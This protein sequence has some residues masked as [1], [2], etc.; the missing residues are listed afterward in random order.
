M[1]GKNEMK[2]SACVIVKNEEKNLPKWLDCMKKIA[3]ELIVVDTG[4]TDCT[5]KLAKESGAV[6][7][8]YDWVNDFASAKNFAITK[9]TGDW[10]LFLDADE[11]FSDE[12]IKKIPLYL[13]RLKKQNWIDAVTCR[14]INIDTDVKGRVINSFSNIRIFR[15][16]PYLRYTNNVHENLVNQIKEL[17]I[18]SLDKVIDVYHTGYSG[19]VIKEKLTRNLHLLKQDI[20]QNG[21]QPKHYR[22][23]CDCYHGLADFENT[24]KYARKH[25]A[26]GYLT[27]GGDHEIYKRLIDAMIFSQK[28]SA[29][30]LCTIEEAIAAYP[31]E[32]TFL[33]VEG[34]FL[35]KNEKYEQAEICLKAALLLDKNKVV[36]EY[37]TDL[38]ILYRAETYYD[39][40]KIMKIKYKNDAALQYMIQ[41]LKKNPYHVKL[42]CF[43]MDFL[44]LNE[45]VKVIQLLNGLY[46]A[47][48]AEDLSFILRYI[49][50][51]ALKEVE[52]YYLNKARANHIAIE[53]GEYRYFYAAGNCKEASSILSARISKSYMDLLLA[54]ILSKD[55][56]IEQT[57]NLMLPELYRNILGFCLGKPVQMQ[58]GERLLY[59]QLQ[60]EAE[61]YEIILPGLPEEKAQK[62][63]RIMDKIACI[64]CV[65][66]EKMYK[67]SL[68]Y[69]A[70][71]KLPEG[72]TIEYIAVRDARS[73]AEGY[74]RAMCQT[75]AKYKIYLHQD[76]FILHEDFF[77]D[78]IRLF[79]EEAD[80]GIIGM[81]GAEKLGKQ[82]IWWIERFVYGKMYHISLKD[83]TFNTKIFGD[84]SGKFQQVT[85]VDGAIMATQYDLPWREDLFDG[86]HF[87]DVSQSLEFAKQGYRVAVPQQT[88]PWCAHASVDHDLEEDYYYYLEIFKKWY[89]EVDT[90]VKICNKKESKIC[91]VIY[92]EDSCRYEELLDYL[93]K[94]RIPEGFDA[95]FATI[96]ET[97]NLAEA[98]NEGM[99]SSTA[100]YKVYLRDHI[101]IENPEFIKELV[102]IFAAYDELGALGVSGA[103]VLP[104]SGIGW[105]SLRRYGK[106]RGFDENQNYEWKQ[107][108]QI[109][110]PVQG[111]DEFFFA[112]QYDLEWRSD[113]FH[114]KS[115]VVASQSVEFQ[116]GKWEVGIVRQEQ[117]WCSYVGDLSQMDEEMQQVFLKE[118][119]KDLFPLVSVLIPTYNRPEYLRIGLESVLRQT[120]ANIEIIIGDD[121]TNNE[122]KTMLRPYLEQHSNIRYI[123]NGGPLG[124]QG[125]INFHRITRLAKG[126]YINYLMDD[127]I[128]H[129]EKIQRMMDYYL[130]FDDVS[131]VTSSRFLIDEEGN[132]IEEAPYV[133]H[134]PEQDM[135]YDGKQFAQSMLFS[136]LN[137]VG[138][139]TT[140]LIKKSFL[141]KAYG[142]TVGS[143]GVYCGIQFGELSDMFQWMELGS[144]GNIIF[145]ADKLSSYRICGER[146]SGNIEV[147]LSTTVDTFIG[148]SISYLRSQ[149]VDTKEEYY[150]LC[151][152]WVEV[153]K[154]IHMVYQKHISDNL[155]L[156]EIWIFYQEI[157]EKLCRRQYEEAFDLFIHRME[158]I[159]E[160]YSM[161]KTFCKKNLTT[162]LWE[163]KENETN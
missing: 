45:S 48:K 35:L 141:S 85:C 157:Y 125:G 46:Q 30:I 68:E 86:W 146:K 128:F 130:Q 71:V 74:N 144:K 23:L 87:Y 114:K 94:L 37:E 117:P 137:I 119:A 60:H 82:G 25:L 3:A 99:R 38:F 92:K 116:R 64:T 111:I 118:Y 98:Y 62:Q 145:L 159:Y 102:E 21:E 27:V 120:Y 22:Y 101:R 65:N 156:P 76:V 58:S 154:E 18:Y 153:Y 126:E 10:I 19:S 8:F 33:F 81:A 112:T 59:E 2:V 158:K 83:G 61:K 107:P 140:P 123:D 79:Q 14:I 11:Y 44:R 55:P 70:K 138:E 51:I 115:F 103:A 84:V 127:D 106:V 134:C 67:T 4:S 89:F 32:A 122:T 28:S 41:G 152:R 139:P 31:E 66:N 26:S 7:Y 95:E 1:V 15:N 69:L 57:C 148:I 40:A 80:I 6:V 75:D 20:K 110:E 133:V 135:R 29:D 129:P 108:R 136:F 88:E 143:F 72:Y 155:E 24:I 105:H 96:T 90:K 13:L 160:G 39:L 161:L 17:G 142:K 73:M 54:S 121:S 131:L 42:F 36:N 132:T 16:A 49:Q 78:I 47:D 50:N 77:I 52:L 124:K 150:A 149:Y 100:K 97:E 5:V 43:L 151:N 104:T 12:C 93:G 63:E 56:E 113:L 53:N 163:K 109:Y 147:L 9:A 91:F 34:D 162:G